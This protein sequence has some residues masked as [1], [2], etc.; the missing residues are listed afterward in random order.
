MQILSRTKS[1][2]RRF[3]HKQEIEDSSVPELQPTVEP[4]HVTN[5]EYTISQESAYGSREPDSVV[6]LTTTSSL[7]TGSMAVDNSF[8]IDSKRSDA[9]NHNKN[10]NTTTSISKASMNS[11]C[12]AIIMFAILASSTIAFILIFHGVRN[13]KKKTSDYVSRNEEEEIGLNTVV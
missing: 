5:E 6:N 2:G 9:S 4:L 12:F 7:L 11:E 8:P 3:D 1:L 10:T 13:R